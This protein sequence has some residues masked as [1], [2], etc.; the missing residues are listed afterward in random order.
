MHPY[1]FGNNLAMFRGMHSGG[2][3][4]MSPRHMCSSYVPSNTPHFCVHLV[5]TI[6][7]AMTQK[8]INEEGS[9]L[10]IMPRTYGGC[11]RLE[12][13][14]ISHSAQMVN[15]NSSNS[16]KHYVSSVSELLRAVRAYISQRDALFAESLETDILRHDNYQSGG[17]EVDRNLQRE[18]RLGL[19]AEIDRMLTEEEDENK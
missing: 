13:I 14:G 7:S 19:V 2:V 10:F 11:D 3:Y 17:T 9:V 18:A 5:Y 6:K 4:S 1:P 8:F 15:P 16:C 12:E